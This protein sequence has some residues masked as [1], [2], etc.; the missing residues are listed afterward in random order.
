M[1]SSP[2]CH[3]VV[4]ILGGGN[5]FPAT[6]GVVKQP[7]VP[8]ELKLTNHLNRNQEAPSNSARTAEIHS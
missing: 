5:L 1:E 3:S 7:N 2:L 4:D 8:L 6:L